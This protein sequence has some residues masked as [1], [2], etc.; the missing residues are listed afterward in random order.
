VKPKSLVSGVLAVFAAPDS[1]R[2]VATYSG[3]EHDDVS[4]WRWD[5]PWIDQ[6]VKW[7]D[8]T[9]RTS[10]IV[11]PAEFARKALEGNNDSPKV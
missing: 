6:G 3:W 8:E 1:W 2:F 5:E 7:N 9:V 11:N 4:H 10:E